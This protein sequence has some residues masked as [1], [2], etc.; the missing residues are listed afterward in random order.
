MRALGRGFSLGLALA[1][2]SVHARAE[3]TG[4]LEG[5]LD[6]AVVSAPSK[7]PEAATLAPATTIVLTA[8]DFERYGIRSL[9][10]AIN[11]LGRGMVVEKTLG[12]GEIGARGVML[13]SDFGSHVLLMVDGHVLNEQWAATAYFDRTATIPFEIID[14]IELVLGPGSVLYGS[15]AMLGIVHIVTKRAKDYAGVHFH[16]DGQASVLAPGRAL[17]GAAGF[18]KAFSL[19]GTRGEVVFEGEYYTQDGPTFD[20]GPQDRGPDS[21]S[22]YRHFDVD[23]KDRKYPAGIWGGRGDDAYYTRAPAGLLKL[24][25]GDFELMTRAALSKRAEPTDSGNFDDPNS[26]QI[27]RFLN[28]DL[29]HTLTASSVVQLSTR[30]YGDVY[31]YN[32]YWTSNGSDDCLPGQEAGCLWRLFGAASWVGLEP[33][34]T[35]DWLEDARLVTLLGMDGR[36][37]HIRSRVHYYDTRTGQ[38]PGAIG[39]PEELEKSL[40]AYAQQTFWVTPDFGLNAGARLDLDERFGAAALPR[41]SAVLVPWRGG[42]LKAIYSEAFRAPTAFDIYYN[43][44]TTQIPGGKS[45]TPERVRS[46]EVSMEQRAGSHI[47]EVSAYYSKWRDLFLGTDA[48]G[49]ALAAASARGELSDGTDEAVQIQNVSRI[50]SYGMDLGYRGSMLARRLGYAI[51][52]TGAFARREEPG[53]ER[54]RLAVMPHAFANARVSY[55]LGG[56]LPTL[57]LAGRFVPRRP[58]ETYPEDTR[59]FAIPFGE[60]RAVISGPIGAT[61]LS[62]S[63][64]GNV[65]TAKTTAYV[66]GDYPLPNGETEKSPNDRLSIGAGLSYDLPL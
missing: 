3:D 4:E 34:L 29:K 23:P 11:F 58:L 39:A 12:T 50:T 15:N 66:A 38:S 24:R 53:G 49:D 32:Q 25:L 8:E 2:L 28:L 56:K 62:Y 44:P 46:A 14:H 42:T 17:R 52:I 33:Q 5:L 48:S 7:A 10:D 1:C 55:E 54:E 36:L 45:L 59:E 18:G 60:I 57:A 6:T 30:L 22:G 35:I 61:G 13:T 27:D 51:G 16:I 19:G 64:S 63:L 31:D 40:A 47:F 20:F 43:D 65:I 21:F 9:D 41:A 26:Y 37:K